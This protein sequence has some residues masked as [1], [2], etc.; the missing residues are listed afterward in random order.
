M[1]KIGRN[2]IPANFELFFAILLF[3]LDGVFVIEGHR[4]KHQNGK[5]DQIPYHAHA[6]GEDGGKNHKQA[7]CN[8]EYR[9]HEPLEG[10]Q[11]LFLALFRP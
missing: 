5:D 2:R 8:G 3:R 4:Q 7:A 1:Q 6:V 9:H 10:M 11:A